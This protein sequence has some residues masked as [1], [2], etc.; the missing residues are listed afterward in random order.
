MRFIITIEDDGY[1]LRYWNENTEEIGDVVVRSWTQKEF[2]NNVKEKSIKITQKELYKAFKI[3]SDGNPF[4]ILKSQDS[5][6]FENL[7]SEKFYIDEELT[8]GNNL[9]NQSY[10][11]GGN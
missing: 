11:A 3:I 8:Y 4:V 7:Q 10:N 2:Y 6:K 1:E 9:S 5:N